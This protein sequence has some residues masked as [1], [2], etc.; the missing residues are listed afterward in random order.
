M[1]STSTPKTM[2]FHIK[3]LALKLDLYALGSTT[4]Q[5]NRGFLTS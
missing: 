3:R 5:I 4:K 2:V 1:G